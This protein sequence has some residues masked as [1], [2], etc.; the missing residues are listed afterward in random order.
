MAN[1][2]S[3]QDGQNG[4]NGQNS[5]GGQ[6]GF[7]EDSNEDFSL[8]QLILRMISLRSNVYFT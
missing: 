6:G 2:F 8:L 5:F 7:G 4:Q 1:H 3:G